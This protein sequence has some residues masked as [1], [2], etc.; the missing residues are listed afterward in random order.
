MRFFIATTLAIGIGVVGCNGNVPAPVSDAAITDTDAITTMDPTDILFT[1]PT[2]N[3]AIPAT[4]QGSTVSPDCIQLYEDDWRQFEFIPRSLKPD[5]DAELAD[6]SAVWDG[7]SVSLGDAGTAFNQVHVRKRIPNVLAIPM[8]LAEFESFI[9]Q[10]AK[11][12]T[13]FGYSEVLRDVHAVA[14]DKLIVYAE[15]QGDT[16]TT[17]GVDA[18]DQFTLPPEFAK[19]L[20]DFVRTHDLMLVHWRSRT[21]LES[22]QDVMRYFGING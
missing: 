22:N 17:F 14:I 3:D 13:F 18:V 19:R 15:I 9:G 1:T 11:P 21:L 6:I 10:K 8:P 7:H 16:I 20:S 5:V 2:L 4:I 12:M